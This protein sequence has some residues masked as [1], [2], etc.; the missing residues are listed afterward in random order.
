MKTKSLISIAVASAAVLSMTAGYA[1][2][3][4]LPPP[5]SKD[6]PLLQ[7]PSVEDV[8]TP[9]EAALSCLNTVLTAQQKKTV[10]GIESFVDHTGKV[11]AV[12]D[13]GTGA[14]ETQGGEEILLAA[15]MKTGVA[16]VN[17]NDI[18]IRKMEYAIKK[19][20][21]ADAEA[22][23]MHIPRPFNISVRLPDVLI[24]GGLDS[25]DN[26]PG[27]EMSGG[28]AGVGGGMRQF[29]ILVT[30]DAHASRMPGLAPDDPVLPGMAGSNI[31]DV[32]LSKQVVGYEARAGI[33]SFWGPVNSPT[34]VQFDWDSQRR[35]ALQYEARVM[36][37]RLAYQLVA[38]VFH[39]SS[40][41]AQI[42][43]ADTLASS[44]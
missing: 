34:N 25:L 22:D 36:I 29:R 9:Y 12:A 44:K 39:V 23:R 14:L 2:A 6:V 28:V 17:T 20:A 10:F 16:T 43:Y 7:G 13:S 32:S 4:V 41:E 15:L 21:D 26:I 37:E 19:E 3:G 31:A 27:W 18:F 40:C 1:S 38:N 42:Q 30:M 24:G 5:L 33:S 8:H 35:E 11:N